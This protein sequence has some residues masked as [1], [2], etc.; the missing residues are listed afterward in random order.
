MVRPNVVKRSPSPARRPGMKRWLVGVAVSVGLALSLAGSA[1]AASYSFQLKQEVVNVYWE[2]DGSAQIDYV[3]TFANDRGASA[4]DYVD[5]GVPTSDYSLSDVSG[6][7]NGHPI[8]D[9]QKS[10]YVSNGAALGL[11]A[12]AIR[13]GATGTVHVGILR[14]GSVLHPDDQSS[15][16]AS[17]VFS[18]TWFDSGLVHGSTDLTVIFH[19]PP[20]VQPTESRYHTA[21]APFP[22]QPDTALDDKGRVMYT[23]HTL[24]ANGSTQYTLGASFPAS[25]VPAGAVVQ[26]SIFAGLIDFV[27]GAV[28]GVANCCLFGGVAA[29]FVAMTGFNMWTNNRRKL[30]YL[31][32]KISIE[33]HGIKRGLTAVE[34]AALMEQPMDKVLTMILFAVIKK[35]AARVVSRDPLKLE[36]AQPVPA[37][38]YPYETAFLDAFASTDPAGRRK[39]LQAAMIALINSVSDKMKGFSRKET[40]AYYQ[41]IIEKAWQ[42]VQAAA[43]PDV[44]SQKFD[45]VMDWTMLDHDFEGRSRQVLG[46]GP[47]FVPMWWGRYSPPVH[48]GL[49]MSGGPMANPLGGSLGGAPGGGALPHLPGGDFAAAI[50]GGIQH[51][52][53]GTIGNLTEFTN[54]ITQKT[55]PPPPPSSSSYRG[56]G[57]GGHSC[58]CACACAG[59][60]CACAGGGR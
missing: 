9:I 7:V 31:P 53:A 26:P 19:L 46:P 37:G 52:S 20:G 41:S 32:P 33:G 4:L 1:L 23:W 13:A 28:P 24:S 6:Q 17:A 49:P 22:A 58:A 5:V 39:S 51:F 3:F 21:S 8:T 12:N 18:P 57:G 47:I 38:L 40:V 15:T 36:R 14:V 55:N 43:T 30:Q 16:D 56:G 34:A 44:K 2:A 27:S 11:G 25:Y 45:E 59:C 10:T 48:T 50:A 60:A 35:S 29:L 54:S 42:E